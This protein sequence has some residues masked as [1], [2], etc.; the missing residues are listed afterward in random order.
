MA[1]CRYGKRVKM[2]DRATDKVDFNRIIEDRAQH[3]FDVIGPRIAEADL[4][5]LKDSFLLARKLMLP[6]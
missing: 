3:V 4:C 5:R 6:R 2:E 1:K